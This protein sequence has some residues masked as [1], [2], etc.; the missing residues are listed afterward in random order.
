MPVLYGHD[1]ISGESIS[2]SDELTQYT[3]WFALKDC[4]FSLTYKDATWQCRVWSGESFISSDQHEEPVLAMHQCYSKMRTN[5][6][7]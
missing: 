4:S 6:K 3:K 2:H 5:G 7:G 1:P